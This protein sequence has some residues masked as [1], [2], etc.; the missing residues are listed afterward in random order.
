MRDSGDFSQWL[1]RAGLENRDAFGLLAGFADRCNE[2]GLRLTRA[3]TI[4]DTRSSCCGRSR[5]FWV[6]RA[7]RRR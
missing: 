1:A 6:W 4:M 7:R 3:M 2:R 5:R